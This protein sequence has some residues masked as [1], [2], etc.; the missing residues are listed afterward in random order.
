MGVNMKKLCKSQK[1]IL[2]GVC[3]GIAEYF[4]IDATIVRLITVVLMFFTGFF[5]MAII[6][7]LATVLIPS[8]TLDEDENLRSANIDDFDKSKTQTNE[9]PMDDED[10]NKHFK[11]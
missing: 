2:S 3:G 8:V 6:Y 1:K 9:Q 5:P 4:N 10:F 11:K 7:I